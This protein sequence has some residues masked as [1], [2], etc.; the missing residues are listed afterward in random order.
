MKTSLLLLPFLLLL[1][2]SCGSDDDLE[3]TV[4]PF[5]MERE[6]EIVEG[7]SQR[8]AIFSGNGDYTLRVADESI[9]SAVYK[10]T[11]SGIDFGAVIVTGLKRG[12]TTVT[13]TDTKA[14]SSVDISVK[15]IS[16]NFYMMSIATRAHSSL[17]HDQVSYLI[18]SD[19]DR[20]NVLSFVQEGDRLRYM[21]R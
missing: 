15:V 14:N 21:K 20:C 8:Q 12:S 10:P 19:K 7:M 6:A 17:K 1:L 13:V 3:R 11:G 9:A 18:P 2:T 16:S 5:N 4:L